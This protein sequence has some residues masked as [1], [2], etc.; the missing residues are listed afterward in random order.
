MSRNVS[1]R[2]SARVRHRASKSAASFIRRRLVPSAKT[3][4]ALAAL[5]A[6]A[7]V[8]A[9]FGDAGAFDAGG[10]STAVVV[11]QTQA[12]VGG[13]GAAVAD[14]DDAD[15]DAFFFASENANAPATKDPSPSFAVYR[16]LGNDMWPLQ[17]VGQMRRN[18]V[19][20]ARHEAAPPPDV[21]VFWIVNR[22]VDAAERKKLTSALAAEKN[23][24][25]DALLFANPPLRDAKCLLTRSAFG[26]TNG[27]ETRVIENENDEKEEKKAMDRAVTFAQAQNA[28]RNAAVAHARERGYDWAVPLDGNQFLPSDFYALLRDA[29]READAEGHV[30]VLIPMLRVREE[31]TSEAYHPRADAASVAKRHV[32]E[33]GKFAVSEPQVALH[34]TKAEALGFRFD[35]SSAYGAGNKAGL[36]RRL[37]PAAPREKS[38]ADAKTVKDSRAR[39]RCCELVDM[40]RRQQ[41]DPYYYGAELDLTRVVAKETKMKEGKDATEKERDALRGLVLE[42]AAKLFAR[43]AVSVR[44]FNYPPEDGP[45]Q[46]KIA[47]SVLTRAKT[48]DEAGEVFREK[49]GAYLE[50][51]PNPKPETCAALDATRATLVADD[52]EEIETSSS[53]TKKEDD[54]GREPDDDAERPSD[55][56]RQTRTRTRTENALRP[57]FVPQRDAAAAGGET[58]ATRLNTPRT[59]DAKDD[60]LESSAAKKSAVGPERVFFGGSSA[61][62]FL[63]F[64]LSCLVLVAVAARRRASS[65]RRRRGKATIPR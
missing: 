59:A 45:S 8:A 37:C 51:A 29:L 16:M 47:T 42:T 35:P 46:L 13:D 33:D 3:M 28:V 44:L 48:R 9:G 50:R 63:F 41:G 40:K 30:A 5:V 25:A 53:E 49:L 32:R 27:D 7:P 54:D 61:S 34:A 36:V 55:A 38:G 11:P 58:R 12:R 4:L 21:P 22:V 60:I 62:F 52:P 64:G 56:T 2:A 43:C 20:A 24:S 17:G 26:E 14:A 1:C 23:V 39:A 19:F 15:A 57:R 31:Q 6:L 65:S 18:S 10:E